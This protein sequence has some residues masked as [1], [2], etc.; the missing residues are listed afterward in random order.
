MEA[1]KRI[2]AALRAGW[3]WQILYWRA[4]IDWE[5]AAHDGAVSD[6]C[7]DAYESLIA[8]QHLEEGWHCVTPPSRA[9]RARQLA[10]QASTELPPG[11]E[12]E[13]Y[14]EVQPTC[15]CEARHEPWQSFR[16]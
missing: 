7:D 9:Y 16:V 15:H 6:R 3:R 10:Q 1:D 14:A 5:I 8:L 12:P 4:V 13:R 11:A 2:P